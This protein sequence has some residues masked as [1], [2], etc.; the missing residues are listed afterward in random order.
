MNIVEFV[1]SAITDDPDILNEEALSTS[2]I[3]PGMASGETPG[4]APAGADKPMNATEISQEA[5]EVAGNKDSSKQAE[6]LLK[7]QEEAKKAEKL[8]RQRIIKPQMEKLN[9]SLDKLRTGVTQSTANTQ[10]AGEKLGNLDTEMTTI[11]TLIGN[12][13]KTFM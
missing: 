5:E 10:N 7:A 1:A 4:G 9:S 13:E 3:A 6:E 12:L 2:G 11:R 8:E